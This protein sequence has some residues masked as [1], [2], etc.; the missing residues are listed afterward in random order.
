MPQAEDAHA[1]ISR[2]VMNMESAAKNEH[3]K[4]ASE[5]GIDSLHHSQ[6]EELRAMVRHI[7]DPADNSVPYLEASSM[8]HEAAAVLI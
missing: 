3:E 4:Q 8:D 5:S 2:Q 6:I 7:N 1:E